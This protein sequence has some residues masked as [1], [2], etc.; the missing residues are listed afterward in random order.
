MAAFVLL[1][2]CGGG[3]KEKD[4]A[5]ETRQGDETTTS[6][7]G[8][9]TTVAPGQPAAGAGG[10][11]TTKPRSS[12]G[13]T[14]GASGGATSTSTSSTLRPGP[15]TQPASKFAAAGN[16]VMRRTGKRTV[17]GLGDQ[18]LDGEGRL[19]VD[20][21]SGNDQHFALEY[22]DG[23]T[24]QTV[25]PRSGGIDL[26][27]LKVTVQASSWEFRPSPVVL[28]APD[29]ASVGSTWSW[30]ITSTDGSLTIDARFKA[31]RNESVT[32]GG[33]AVNTVVVEG[34]STL[35]GAVNGT[36]K[37]TLWGSERYRLIVRTE[38]V[39][40]TSTPFASHSESRSEL[41]STKPG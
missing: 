4:A 12:S 38:D 34:T 7:A 29:P 37:Q 26:A 13:A 31:V 15:T 33:E 19:R 32:I 9:D 14:G 8:S 27:Y 41:A 2:A 25:R 40:D 28:F 22:G 18:S 20:P 35:S 10:T 21:P 23:G 16:Y 6:V 5:E 11:G 39:T 36:L 24:A 30:R 17:T 3:D 1:A